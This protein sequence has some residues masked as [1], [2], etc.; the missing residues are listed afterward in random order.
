MRP[1]I[2]A[3]LFLLS[4]YVLMIYMLFE[5]LETY[6]YDLLDK[7]AS[8]TQLLI[9]NLYENVRV[10]AGA[11]SEEEI[12]EIDASIKSVDVNKYIKE[13]EDVELVMMNDGK[14]TSSTFDQN[15]NVVLSE[16]ARSTVYEEKKT[17][18]GKMEIDG[19]IWYVHIEPV[20]DNK[21]VFNSYAICVDDALIMTP[22]KN[23]G[24]ILVILAFVACGILAWSVISIIFTVVKP[25]QRIESEVSSI[26]TGNL[27]TDIQMPKNGREIVSLA[28]GVTELQEKMRGVLSPI[29]DLTGVIVGNVNQLSSSSATLSDSANQ[30]AA[31]LEEISSTMEEM[32]ANIQQNTDNSVETNK[33]AESVSKMLEDLGVS[34]KK[35]FDA[36]NNIAENLEGINELVS[37]TN[38]LALNASVEAARAGEQGK[39]F[40]VVAKEVGR[41]A[42]QTRETS[43]GINETA[44]QSIAEADVA[45]KAVSNLLPQIER[46][47]ALIKEITVASIEQNTSVGHVNSAINEL[48]RVTQANAASAEE[49]E[50]N[51]QETQ[52]LLDQ[53]SESVNVFKI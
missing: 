30:Q 27:R 37:Q 8:A 7:K 23:I 29:V 31:S 52:K 47:V 46:M 14:V 42:D 15:I 24:F 40:A 41:L 35:S 21:Q 6:T 10:G 22:I 16:E 48:N 49:L 28:K 5:H 34:S 18:T 9:T 39:G 50:A 43:D 2:A 1:W 17:W 26:A 3:I 4:S 13:V 36:I 20:A 32:G 44:Q 33:M 45:F 53:I 38:I 51:M 11:T 25:V 19:E 12:A